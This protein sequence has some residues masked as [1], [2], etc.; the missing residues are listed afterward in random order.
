MKLTKLLSIYSLKD[1]LESF[2]ENGANFIAI[3]LWLFIRLK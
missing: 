2:P 3:V 1:K